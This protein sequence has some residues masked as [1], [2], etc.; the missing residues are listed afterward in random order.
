MK[1][2]EI[3]LGNEL[4][5][6]NRAFKITR[7]CLVVFSNKKRKCGE[8]CGYWGENFSLI[9]FV[10][11]NRRNQGDPGHY[12]IYCTVCKEEITIAA[13]VVMSSCKW[14]K[15]PTCCSF[16]KQVKETYT[17]II[18]VFSFINT[19]CVL[20]VQGIFPMNRK[21]SFP[22]LTGQNVMGKEILL[23]M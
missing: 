8:R 19:N 16:R 5:S 6:R 7:K 20:Y 11:L 14:R 22:Y 21:L 17:V 13:S 10:G 18:L 3:V 4:F 2:K 9:M 12:R 1:G 23:V 15:F